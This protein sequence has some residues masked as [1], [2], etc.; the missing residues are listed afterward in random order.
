MKRHVS[1]PDAAS[2]CKEICKTTAS[3]IY[4]AALMVFI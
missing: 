3:A 1:A 4:D 2:R